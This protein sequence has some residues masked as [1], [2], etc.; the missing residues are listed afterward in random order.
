MPLLLWARYAFIA[1]IALS[2]IGLFPVQWFPLQL[3]KLVAAAFLISIAGLLFILGGG[4]GGV[5]GK[6]GYRA[7]WLVLLLPLTYAISYAVSADRSA[8]LLGYSVEVDT[9]CFVTIASL[10]FL[11]SFFL[12]RRLGSVRL[13]LASISTVGLVAL[14]F[15]FISIFFGTK[16]LPAVF[17]DPSINLVGKWNDLGLLVGACLLMILICLECLSLSRARQIILACIALVAVLFL[18]LVQYP[19]IWALL[20]GMMF[21]VGTW[22]FVTTKKLPWVSIVSGAICIFFLVWGAGVQTGLVKVFPVSSFE[23]RPALSTT[24]EIVRSSHGTSVKDFLVGTGPGTFASEWFLHKPE[25]I[26]QSQFWNVGFSSG[27]S[28]LTTAL[29]TVGLLGLLAWFIPLALVLVGLIQV[30]RRRDTFNAYEQAAMAICVSLSAYLWVAA[31]VYPPSQNIL[32]LAFAITGAAFALSMKSDAADAQTAPVWMQRASLGVAILILVVLATANVAIA[33]RF[34]T[35]KHVNQGAVALGNGDINTALTEANAALAVEKTADALQ[36]G[37]QAGIVAM[38]QIAQSTSTPTQEVQQ[39]FATITQTTISL[40]QQAQSANPNDYRAYF[41]T[42]KIYDLLASIGVEGAYEQA[43]QSYAAAQKLNPKNPEI[44]LGIARLEY[45]HRNTQGTMD[46]LKQ[47]LTLKQDYTDAILFAVQ[48]Y[49]A[50]KDIKN[51]T[52]AAQAAVNSA[53]GVASLWFQLG[54]LHYSG[55]NMKDAAPALEQAVKLQPDY[56]NAKYF[57][58][59]SYAELKRVPEAIQQFKDIASTNPDNAEVKLILSNLEAG[60]APF[61]GAQ[62]PVTSN[63]ENRETAPISQ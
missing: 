20:L 56:A 4:L 26:N 46:A 42:A 11:I 32:L 27:Y 31:F 10:T 43:K 12:F 51:A 35:E 17:T 2:L 45:I 47:A 6:K 44:S 33:K 3:G 23:I 30:V 49:V 62:P 25:A 22:S 59:L 15:Q 57:L 58:G 13:L 54:L 38:Q 24:L 28:T 19:A 18:A 41:G 8:G 1:G 53:P 55:N 29:G 39:Q 50:E 60:K 40:G 37:V 52:I 9:I 36:F 61:D 21:V 48:M 5:V 16:I 14:V 7:V 63:P 34:V